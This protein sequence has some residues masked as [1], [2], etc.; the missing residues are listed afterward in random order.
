[1]IGIIHFNPVFAEQLPET[2]TL[3]LNAGL[4]IHDA[5]DR[6]TLHGSR[7]PHGGARTDSDIDLCLLVNDRSLD[8]ASDRDALLRSIVNTTLA[9][10]RSKVECDLAAVFDKT[11]C[12]L[13]CLSL[14]EFDSDLCPSTVDCMGL[15]KIQKGYNGFVTGPAVD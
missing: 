11:Q 2:Q 8:V 9:G 13:R 6:I 1:M 12:G 4:R 14:N 5:V 10:W 15:F 7:G 3:L